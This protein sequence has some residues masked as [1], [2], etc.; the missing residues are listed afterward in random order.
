MSTSYNA[1]GTKT[2]S[3]DSPLD[4]LLE[5]ILE[6]LDDLS[7]R[8]GECNSQS[9]TDYLDSGIRTIKGL[10]FQAQRELLA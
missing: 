1:D 2:S 8:A 4:T 5:E 7:L 3:N 6:R 10:V 9:H